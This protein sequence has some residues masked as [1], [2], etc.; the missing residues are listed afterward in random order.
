MCKE[1]SDLYRRHY[2]SSDDDHDNPSTIEAQGTENETVIH[3][4]LKA[5]P[6]L[7]HSGRLFKERVDS[8]M[9]VYGMS[10]LKTDASIFRYKDIRLYLMAWV[11]DWFI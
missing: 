7:P 2:G 9:N 4:L 6:G 8:A 10:T 11:D 5:L 1:L 3:L